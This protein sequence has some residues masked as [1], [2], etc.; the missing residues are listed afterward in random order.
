M[1]EFIPQKIMERV[2]GRKAEPPSVLSNVLNRW[3][4][5]FLPFYDVA[6][7]GALGEPERR[8]LRGYLFPEG[9]LLIFSMVDALR[10]FPQAFPEIDDPGALAEQ[11]EE[12]LRCHGD[13]SRLAA[14]HRA[15]LRGCE[16]YSIRHRAS[17]VRTV[18]AIIDHDRQLRGPDGGQRQGFNPDAKQRPRWLRGP[19]IP[20]DRE[21]AMA[22]V[23]M[24]FRGWQEVTVQGG[25]ATRMIP[26]GL[27]G[28]PGRR[29]RPG[30]VVRLRPCG[31][32]LTTS[33][34]PP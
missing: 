26:F 24:I 13:W 33:G 27:S 2:F 22:V 5:Q 23:L 15:C 25:S 6:T 14:F 20:P 16:D 12:D 1:F 34:V 11:L 18:L 8:S 21:V 19:Q 17:A 3:F 28:G 4:E 10:Q 29:R 31:P 30:G 32:P 9:L 7:P